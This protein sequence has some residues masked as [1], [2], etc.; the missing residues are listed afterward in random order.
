MESYSEYETD[1]SDYLA[2]DIEIPS[3]TDSDEAADFVDETLT[4]YNMEN[5]ETRL[6]NIRDGF[7]M[8]ASRY[9]D[10]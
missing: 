4:M 5:I 1:R 2:D 9:E 7:M 8:A 6:V 3:E 10:I